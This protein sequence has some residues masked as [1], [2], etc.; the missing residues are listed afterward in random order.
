LNIKVVGRY[1][2]EGPMSEA[3]ASQEQAA[4]AVYAFA[5]EQLKAGAT[6]EQLH[7]L[8]VGKGLSQEIA[9]TVV[10]NLTGMRSNAA[11]SAGRKHMIAGA[12]W[13]IGGIIVTAVTYGAASEGGGTYFVAWGAI[14]FGGI[15]FFRGLAQSGSA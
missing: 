11:R 6:P 8:L 9:A 2:E 5:A 1:E 7:A 13:C 10:G 15:Q 12:L 4:Q 3:Q 14:I